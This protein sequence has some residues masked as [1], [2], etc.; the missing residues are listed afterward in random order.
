MMKAGFIS[1][2]IRLLSSATF[3]FRIAGVWIAYYVLSAIWTEG[4]F[5]AFAYGLSENPL[6]QVPFLLFLISGFL[7]LV[8]M[9]REEAGKGIARL[10]T[11]M[12]LPFGVF[13]LLAGYFISLSTRQFDWVIAAEGHTFKPPWG[14][15]SFTVSGIRPG[16]KESFLDSDEM[17][18]SGSDIFAYEPKATIVDSASKPVVIGAFPPA[19][20]GNSYGHILNFGLAPGIRLTEGDELKQ[21]G[22]MPL[23][24]LPP[25]N[26]DSFEIQP[27]PYLFEVS[28]EPEKVI[29]KGRTRASQYNLKLPR[30]RVRVLK[31]EKTI[32]ED[33]STD[34]LS[35]DN[36]TISFFE[37]TYW[38]QIELVKDRGALLV[39]AGLFLTAVGIPIYVVRYVL[40]N[41]RWLSRHDT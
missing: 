14:D 9:L 31:G 22:Y 34:R 19:R 7:N 26:N 41:K 5:A 1:R 39:L 4:A 40:V 20:I 24:L 33:V 11:K 25:G 17:G 23:R 27:Y 38:I 16:I 29:E 8:R 18:K 35:F 36:L 12:L 15:E 32:A 13:I 10:V 3:L 21:E 6:V 37:P 30:Y 28:L 2:A